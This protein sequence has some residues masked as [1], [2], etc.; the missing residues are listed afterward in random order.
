MEGVPDLRARTRRRFA[1]AALAT[2]AVVGAGVAYLGGDRA[3]V[4]HVARAR[5]L[6]AARDLERCLLGADDVRDDQV[7]RTLYLRELD[8]AL[9]GAKCRAAAK[10]TVAQ[11]DDDVGRDHLPDEDAALA[12]ALADDARGE[13]DGDRSLI[14]DVRGDVAAIE[15][16][17]VS[18][19]VDRLRPFPGREAPRNGRVIDDLLVTEMDATDDGRVDLQRLR[20]DLSVAD[21]L[22]VTERYAFGD[23]DLVYETADG[24]LRRWRWNP[25]S[26]IEIPRPPGDYGWIHAWRRVTGGGVG[27]F[28]TVHG[29]WV[30]R[31]DD[32]FEPIGD[33]HELVV[34]DEPRPDVAIARDGTV[35]LLPGDGDTCVAD[36]AIWNVHDGAVSTGA[37]GRIL[38]AAGRLPDGTTP[39]ARA[40]DDDHLFVVGQGGYFVCDQAR[41]TLAR[42][43]PDVEQAAVR[44]HHPGAEVIAGLGLHVVAVVDDLR[45]DG[46]VALDLYEGSLPFYPFVFRGRWF[47]ARPGR[48]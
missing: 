27:V 43:L 41:C 33:G 31:F 13:V 44:A 2:V 3:H 39:I 36:D 37:I 48:P 7:L 9:D 42:A 17:P 6:G 16:T 10:A 5:L 12:G 38:L 46:H 35:G 22:P 8:G 20:P 11:L 23:G 1:I 19:V 21:Q 15:G 18:T 29:Y 47:D 30:Q 34:D 24:H 4:R 32:H 28:G 25:P 14:H 45:G 40:C 26:M